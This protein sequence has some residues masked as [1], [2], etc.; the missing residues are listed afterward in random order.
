MRSSLLTIS[1]RFAAVVLTFALAGVAQAADTHQVPA[2]ATVH[3]MQRAA[4][5][6]NADTAIG[7]NIDYPS[8]LG[9]EGPRASATAGRTTPMA[10]SRDDASLAQQRAGR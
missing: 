6:G 2:T 9:P 1:F 7:W 4:S 10:G 3:D 8:Q 5:D